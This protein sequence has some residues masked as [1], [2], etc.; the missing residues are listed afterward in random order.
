MSTHK[1]NMKIKFRLTQ[2]TQV[3]TKGLSKR[4]ATSKLLEKLQG[5]SSSAGAGISSFPF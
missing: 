4:P 2:H 1:Q 5:K 3:Q